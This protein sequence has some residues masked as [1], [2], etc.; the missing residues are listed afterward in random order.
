MNEAMHG[1]EMDVKELFLFCLCLSVYY[2]KKGKE[3]F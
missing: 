2:R 3:D 1:E